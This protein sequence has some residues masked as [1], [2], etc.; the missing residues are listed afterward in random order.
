MRRSILAA[1]TIVTLAILSHPA[2]A[3]PLSNCNTG[4]DGAVKIALVIGNSSYVGKPVGPAIQDAQDVA[5]AMCESDGFAYV[6]LLLDAQ[7]ADDIQTALDSLKKER[8]ARH[9]VIVVLYYSGHGISVG[10]DNFLVPVGVDVV[11]PLSNQDVAD[12]SIGM[13]PVFE[14]LGPTSAATARIVILDDCRAPP[15]IGTES[16]AAPP[17]SITGHGNFQIVSA[18]PEGQTVSNVL[19]HNS[20]FTWT[21]LQG[22]KIKNL[23]IQI[24]HDL[25]ATAMSGALARA[26]V[27]D[28][29][30]YAP[31]YGELVGLHYYYAGANNAPGA[32]ADPGSAIEDFLAVAH[33][34]A[35]RVAPVGT[36]PYAYDPNAS[37]AQKKAL[38]AAQAALTRR[39]GGNPAPDFA[40]AAFYWQ[41]AMELGSVSATRRLGDLYRNGYGIKLDYAAACNLYKNAA[42]QGDVIAIER[43]GDCI[44]DIKNDPAAALAKYRRADQLG[45]HEALSGAAYIY[46]KHPE[47]AAHGIQDSL[48]TFVLAEQEGAPDAAGWIG[49]LY[50]T[51]RVRPTALSRAAELQYALQ[52]FERGSAAGDVMATEYLARVYQNGLNDT[53]PVQPD[54]KKSFILFTQAATSADTWFI[55]QYDLLKD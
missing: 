18:A 39:R 42:D 11:H 48:S 54:P 24:L 17:D 35:A 30:A 12:R 10:G 23:P 41:K 55:R 47:L 7:K 4:P 51:G 45:F 32:V 22:I 27:P 1:A 49:W 6:D 20:A 29:G 25:I 14:S 37:V 31:I 15:I 34:E 9:P 26:G 50:W 3:T 21:F 2:L 43:V 8:L 19:D 52:A 36:F 13:G 16:S 5:K 46:F 38:D 53:V 33:A 28:G 44:R 40:A